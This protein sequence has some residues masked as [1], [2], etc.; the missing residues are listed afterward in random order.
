MP[1]NEVI[2]EMRTG[3]DENKPGNGTKAG[4]N[5]RFWTDFVNNEGVPQAGF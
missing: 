4:Q 1:I 2:I 5:E 3:L